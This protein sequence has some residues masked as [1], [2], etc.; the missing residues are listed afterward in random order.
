MDLTGIGTAIGGLTSLNVLKNACFGDKACQTNREYSQK[1]DL[2]KAETEL[3]RAENEGSA[4]NFA[5]TKKDNT[6]IILVVVG[7]IS[8]ILVTIVLVMNKRKK[9]S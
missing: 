4:V 8:I 6:V 9:T 3:K 7:V 2:T 5:S 1:I